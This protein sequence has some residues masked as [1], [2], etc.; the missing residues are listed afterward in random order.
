MSTAATRAAL[1][2]STAPARDDSQQ[3]ALRGEIPT[4]DYTARDADGFSLVIHTIPEHVPPDRELP[5]R[6]TAEQTPEPTAPETPQ[7]EDP[8]EETDDFDWVPTAPP[9]E[10]PS[11]FEE[12]L[13]DETGEPD[14]FDSGDLV[15][16][17]MLQLSREDSCFCGTRGELALRLIAAVG[18]SKDPGQARQVFVAYKV[19]AGD[20]FPN[21]ARTRDGVVPPKGVWDTVCDTRFVDR[22]PCPRCVL[23]YTLAIPKGFPAERATW[24]ATDGSCCGVGFSASLVEDLRQTKVVSFPT[25]RF[26]LLDTPPSRIQEV[27]CLRTTRGG[28]LLS[29]NPCRDLRVGAFELTL[30]RGPWASAALRSSLVSAVVRAVTPADL[31]RNLFERQLPAEPPTQTELPVLL[32]A[33]CPSGPVV[34]V[35]YLAD[36]LANL[37]DGCSDTES[38]LLTWRAV[39]LLFGPPLHFLAPLPWG[40][41]VPLA[42]FARCY[43]DA[44]HTPTPPQLSAGDS[45]RVARALFA[46]VAPTD[47]LSSNSSAPPR[48]VGSLGG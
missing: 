46:S 38:A 25:P 36:L 10:Q 42:E 33:S 20:T 23:P 2:A 32:S 14:P 19:W 44:P 39:S 26:V 21:R 24:V 12:D 45:S 28:Q 17:A 27:V 1:I 8:E 3:R 43:P 29:V 4:T 6:R 16:D 48:P 35:G 9:S 31:Y 11:D 15:T 5:P 37:P 40:S 18:L 22:L 13:P 34:G 7:E 41:V 47:W 30:F